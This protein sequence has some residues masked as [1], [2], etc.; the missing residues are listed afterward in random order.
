MCVEHYNDQYIDE[1]ERRDF[2]KALGV[3]GSVGVGGK[4]TLESIQS[5]T[6]AG[7]AAELESMGKALRQDLSGSL[8]ASVLSAGSA[9][10]AD[11]LDRIPE[12]AAMGIPEEVGTAYS[13]LAEPGWAINEH[14]LE[15]GFYSTAEQH[16]EPFTASHVAES[17]KSVISSGTLSGLLAEVGFDASE[18]TAL[19]MS[20]VNNNAHLSKWMPIELYPDELTGEELRPEFVPPVHHRA[21]EG[22]LHW[23]DGLDNWLWQNGVL[24]TDDLVS[25]GVSDIKAMLGGL[26]LFGAAT[27]QLARGKISDK[28]LSALL[29]A[30][31]ATMIMGQE[32]L[33]DDM[34]RISD[35]ER[36]PRGGASQ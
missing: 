35:T 6:T 26:Y 1:N 4:F 9:G 33:A 10:V 18:R 28:E 27:E 13:E 5:A 29:T 32:H 19:M 15:V 30:G 24:L 12:I 36:A 25:K 22:S 11:Q 34:I 8:T 14:L 3:A 7:G 21:A 16:L 23:L 31:S 20:V 17:A 2:L